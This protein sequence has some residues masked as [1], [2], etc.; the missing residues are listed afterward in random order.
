MSTKWIGPDENLTIG[1]IGFLVRLHQEIEGWERVILRDT[2][3]YTHR[4]RQPLLEGWCGS[5]NNLSTYGEGMAKVER[6]ARNGRAL[7]RSLD[8]DELVAALEELGYPELTP[9]PAC[10][11]GSF[12]GS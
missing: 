3:V 8:G 4:S 6:I 7:V 12:D 2:P 5:F 10:A 11:Q 1:E 9:D